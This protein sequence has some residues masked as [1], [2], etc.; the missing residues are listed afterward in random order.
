[1][2]IVNKP[3]VPA[4]LYLVINPCQPAAQLF[5]RLQIALAEGISI[6]QI[7]DN[8]PANFSQQETIDFCNKIA[9]A[10]ARYKVPVLINNRYSLIEPCQ[11]QGVHFDTPP[12]NLA[13]VRQTVP[14]PIITGLT[15]GNNLETLTQ[16]GCSDFDYVSFCSVFPSQS[17]DVCEIVSRS[18]IIKA[19]KLSDLPMYASGG[20]KPE[21]VGE[22]N[23]LGLRGIALISGIMS[24]QN[25]AEFIKIY[26]T[27][28]N[29]EKI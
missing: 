3:A 14:Y 29:L 10:A 7:W 22:L 12:N 20:I 17:V 11:L 18:T 16:A 13:K 26:R 2:E 27:K 15:V 23:G 9:Q 19:R 28:F 25:P 6:V 4:G 1:M 24:H 21:N 8:W 5:P